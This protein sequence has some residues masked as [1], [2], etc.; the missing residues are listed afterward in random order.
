[1]TLGGIAFISYR[2][3]LESPQTV[4]DQIS[5]II[6]EDIQTENLQLFHKTAKDIPFEDVGLKNKAEEIYDR[7]LATSN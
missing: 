3:F 7:L 1:L 5:S 6:G 4:L 2:S